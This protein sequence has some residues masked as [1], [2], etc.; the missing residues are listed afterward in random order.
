MKNPFAKRGAGSWALLP[1]NTL[2]P[3]DY[4]GNGVPPGK[5]LLRAYGVHQRLGDWW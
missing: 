1:K 4:G 5:S 3:G 2:P